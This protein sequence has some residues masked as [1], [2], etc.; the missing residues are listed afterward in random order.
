MLVIWFTPLQ[1]SAAV[2]IVE[3]ASIS[4]HVPTQDA[5]RERELFRA[6]RLWLHYA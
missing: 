1:M 6:L 3:V 2:Q 4:G 5:F